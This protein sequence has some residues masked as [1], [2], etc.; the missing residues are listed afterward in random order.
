VIEELRHVLD[1]LA[2]L[3][4]E[5]SSR[6]P[7]DVQPAGRQS[8]RCQ[9]A[10]EARLHAAYRAP[11]APTPARQRVGVLWTGRTTTGSVCGCAWGRRRAPRLRPPDNWRGRVMRWNVSESGC[12]WQCSPGPCSRSV[13]AA[14][15]PQLRLRH[16]S[17][18]MG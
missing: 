12:L 7:K 1:A 5:P 13:L 16:Q 10:A 17:L 18:S 4:T 3:P 6:M 8:S 15:A 2:G 11:W 9:V 14:A